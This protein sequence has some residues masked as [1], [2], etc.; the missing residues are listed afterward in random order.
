M[1]NI[2][3][4]D[5]RVITAGSASSHFQLGLRLLRYKIPSS[6]V[7]RVAKTILVDNDESSISP[8]ALLISKRDHNNDLVQKAQDWIDTHLAKTFTLKDLAD[9]LN[10]SEKTVSRNFKL[11]LSTTPLQY[12]QRLRIQTAKYLLETSTLSLDKIMSKVGYGDRSGFTKLF[13][14]YTGLP[15]ITY[16]RQFQA[17]HNYRL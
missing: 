13:T 5:K 7:Q 4:E 10:T 8:N 1:N 16:R 11:A 12:T 17:G 2:L 3:V 15:P 14:K 6:I 9:C